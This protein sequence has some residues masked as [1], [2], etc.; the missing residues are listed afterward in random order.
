MKNNYEELKGITVEEKIKFTFT[1]RGDKDKLEFR[2]AILPEQGDKLIL[3]K[4]LHQNEID[5]ALRKATES[6]V[7]LIETYLNGSS[8]FTNYILLFV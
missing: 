6:F 5:K 8:S 2:T 7:D 4:F 3:Y 1:F